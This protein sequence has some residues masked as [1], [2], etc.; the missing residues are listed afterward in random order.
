LLRRD[1]AFFNLKWKNKIW[2]QTQKTKL[3]KNKFRFW[4]NIFQ[5]TI[6]KSVMERYN[7]DN[8]R[9]KVTPE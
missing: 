4:K 5:K 2:F 9:H 6:D 8:N 7:K 3:I 1:K